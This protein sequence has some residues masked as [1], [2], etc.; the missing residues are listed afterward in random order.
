MSSWKGGLAH[1]ASAIDHSKDQ[2]QINQTACPPSPSKGGEIDVAGYQG[3]QGILSLEGYQ[4]FHR[5]A[6]RG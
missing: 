5:V 1:H 3:S 4:S 2:G 6:M